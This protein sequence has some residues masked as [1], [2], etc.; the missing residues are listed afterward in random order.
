[1]KRRLASILYLA[2]AGAWSASPQAAV[3]SK[4]LIGDPRA[5][6][7]R[8][9]AF[10]GEAIGDPM[11]RGDFAWVNV[12]DS[13]AAIGVFLPASQQRTIE[14]FGSYR[15]GGDIIRVLGV[16]HRA[17]PEHGGDMDI[18]G[19]SVEAISRGR[20]TPHPVSRI[21]L[22]LIPVFFILAAVLWRFSTS[23][24]AAATSRKP[25]F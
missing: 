12:L 14:N 11:R 9:I 5:Y 13:Y 21:E 10:E 25:L 18:H 23:R 8:E 4:E 20:E 19:S 15:R 1:M 6:D 7:G 2:L 22:V 3:P 24:E 17:C 16:F